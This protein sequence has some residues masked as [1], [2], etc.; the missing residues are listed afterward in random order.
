[1]SESVLYIRADA[2]ERIG[3]GHV[4]RMIALG[5]AWAAD[6]GT[7]RFVSR[8]EDGLATWIA[9][10]GFELVRLESVA[11]CGL[12]QLLGMTG[13]GD[14]IVLDGYDFGPDMQSE[15]R[16][17]GRRVLLVDDINDRER[18]EA[19]I[20]LNQNVGADRF[21]YVVNPD[22][23][24]L[25]GPRHAMLREIFLQAGHVKEAVPERATNIMV[26]FGGFDTGGM[27]G[28]VLDALAFMQESSL[29]VRVVAG[30]DGAHRDALQRQADQ[31]AMPVDILDRVEDMQNL[32]CWADLAISSAGSTCWEMCFLGLPAL[33]VALVDNQ[34]HIADGLEKAG[35]ATTFQPD[36]TPEALAGLLADLCADRERRG[37][38]ARKGRALVDGRGASR[39]VRAMKEAS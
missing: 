36:V 30:S 21:E 33:L 13:A 24:L 25:L 14:W 34:A 8:C 9:A 27:A 7:V 16:E 19:D 23:T 12:A 20:L 38:M 4:V 31:L 35:A 39:I 28:R 10:E 2:D 17:A 6:G 15:L 18:Y 1:M 11:D 22:G 32:M 29:H 3:A 37:E 26:M 5:Q